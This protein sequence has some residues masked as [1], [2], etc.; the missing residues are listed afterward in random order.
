MKCLKRSSFLD[1]TEFDSRFLALSAVDVEF[2]KIKVPFEREFWI[3]ESEGQ[4]I[5]RI[6]ANVSLTKPSVGY[7]GFFFCPS[8]S[9]VAG[10]TLL[11]EAMA[12][13]SEKNRTTLY[14]PVNFSSWHSYRLRVDTDPD[15][16]YSWEPLRDPLLKDLLE[17]SRFVPTQ[18]YCS[19][20]FY[21]LDHV[22]KLCAPFV[23]NA[24]NQGYQF[25]E[26]DLKNNLSR[27]IKAIQSI[28]TQSFTESFL[29][30]PISQEE[31]EKLYAPPLIARDVRFSHFV[32]DSQGNEIA[33]FFL[34]IERATTIVKTIAVHRAHQAMGLASGCMGWAAKRAYDAGFIDTVGALLN[35]QAKSMHLLKRAA[36]ETWT[37][38]YTLF[39]RE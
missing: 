38:N 22:A 27:E 19:K 1:T 16:G 18:F 4:D 2:L 3:L 37:H 23:Q 12:W 39:K 8:D 34:F 29:A 31:Y 30:E 25:R 6:G 28:N 11:H 10:K 26:F 33:Y 21:G 5:A 36:Q 14:A 13:L 9:R 15:P 17:E 24:L 7:L 35:T 20:G 32:L